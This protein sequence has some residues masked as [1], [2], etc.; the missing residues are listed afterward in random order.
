M[1]A[2]LNVEFPRVQARRVD[3]VLLLE[4]GSI[5]HIEIQSTNGRRIKYRM[6]TYYAL[7]KETYLLPVRQ[8]VL[9][10]GDKPMTMP[11][12]L[13]E[14]GNTFIYELIDI[15]DF[16]AEA[17]MATGRPADLALAI[18]G[19]GG[20]LKLVQILKE[21]AKLEGAERDRVLAQVLLASVRLHASR[22]ALENRRGF[23]RV[24]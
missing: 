17:M 8:V 6:V 20:K 24:S 7:I 19:G 18:L 10:V 5:L 9:Y 14:D 1:R 3:L 2:F 21:A 4:D 23:V 13:E 16:D 22:P 12:R 15:R 11:D